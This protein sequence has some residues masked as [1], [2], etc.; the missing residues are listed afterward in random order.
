MNLV[1]VNSSLDWLA[2]KP[3]ESPWPHLPQMG[4]PGLEFF[5][6]TLLL[7]DIS[8]HETTLSGLTVIP[9]SV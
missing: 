6:T 7:K 4:T 8:S 9:F 5:S 2:G 3:Q 1:L